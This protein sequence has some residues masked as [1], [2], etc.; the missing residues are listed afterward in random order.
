MVSPPY[1]PSVCSWLALVNLVARFQEQRES[2]CETKVQVSA[3]VTCTALPFPSKTQGQ[4]QGPCGDTAKGSGHSEVGDSWGHCLATMS[5]WNGTKSR[6][7]VGQSQFLQV[8][9]NGRQW[10]IGIGDI[11]KRNCLNGPWEVGKEEGVEREEVD[12]SMN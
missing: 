8:G 3:C 11:G 4:G 10:S 9:A 1:V 7:K 6:P 5:V 12:A 2:P